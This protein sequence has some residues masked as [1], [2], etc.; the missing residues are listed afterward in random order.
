MV[1]VLL[2]AADPLCFLIVGYA[3]VLRDHAP[4][5]RPQLA[6]IFE[7]GLG[8]FALVSPATDGEVA[9]VV[10]GIWIFGNIVQKLWYPRRRVA[11]RVHDV[12]VC[13]NAFSTLL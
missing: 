5:C 11:I 4:D 8:V 3:I 13:F 2:G 6:R 7:A 10:C 9:D 12:G 1:S